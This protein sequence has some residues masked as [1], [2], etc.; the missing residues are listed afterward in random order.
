MKTY[1]LFLTIL[2]CS[3]LGFS[4]TER[5]CFDDKIKCGFSIGTNYS[6]LVSKE[7]LPIDS[8]I[9]NGLGIVVGLNMDYK[10]TDNFLFSPKAELSFN[11]SGIERIVN[12][13]VTSTYKAYSTSIDIMT[14]FVYRIGK[15]N[16]L[17]YLLIGPKLSIPLYEKTNSPTKFKN[18]TNLSID[19]G[20]GLESKLKYFFFSPEIRYSYGLIDIN[21]HPSFGILNYHKIS[22]MMNF[23]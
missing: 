1:I 18:K 8:E 13:N 6:N 21:K 17:P 14:H 7:V 4:Q 2:F 11:K 10:F 22:L 23:K 9:Y 3:T 16:T 5:R 20:F 19:I 15:S 12:D